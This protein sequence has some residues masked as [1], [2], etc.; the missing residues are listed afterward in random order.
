MVHAVCDDAESLRQIIACP[1]LIGRHESRNLAVPVGGL[2]DGIN[3]SQIVRIFKLAGYAHEICQIEMTQ[4]DHIDSVHGGN[5]VHG[6]DAGGSLN[7][8]DR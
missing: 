2:N 1:Y 6:F 5:F 4:P 3:R 7:K 8:G